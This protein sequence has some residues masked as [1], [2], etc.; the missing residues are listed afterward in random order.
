MI[1][2]YFKIEL[3]DT[4][5]A[6]VSFLPYTLPLGL[7]VV[8][9]N[10]W[11]NYVRQFYLSKVVWTLLEIKLPKE[12]YKSPRAMEVV[13]SSFYQASNPNFYD[14]YW[15]GSVRLWS[16]LELVSI[17]GNV[18][19]FVRINA[20]IKNTVESH[21]Y[22]QFPGI[23][24]HEVED[25]VFNAPYL[26]SSDWDLFGMEYKLNKEDAYPI[27]TYVDYGMEKDPIDELYRIDPM[28]A[29]LEFLGSL[30]PGEQVWVQIL[31]MAAQKR[32]REKGIWFKK[33]DWKDQAK[34]II[35]KIMKRD[36]KKEE[37]KSF[38]S[39]ALSPGERATLEA[40]EKSVSK[41][42]FDCGI[43]T[44]Y[45]AKKEKFDPARA[46]SLGGI[47]RQYNTL[48]LNGFKT[49][50]P[51]RFDWWEDPFDFRITRRKRKIF[52]GY[53]D[54]GY[55]YHPHERTPFVLNT[56][57]LATIFHFP[58]KV[59]EVPTFARI[60]SKKSEPPTNLPI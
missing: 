56:E 50:R 35:D 13:L 44:I 23:E 7:A 5:N 25:Y 52:R 42:G 12:T 46:I 54:R 36:K 33:E 26:S 15:E 34:P 18:Y 41:L 20:K 27:K 11:V 60:E 16:S 47:F 30:G 40:L 4:V 21:I 19:F 32:F 8:F 22:S 43:R 39:L 59:A 17:E 24:I 49:I 31:A 14:K 57:E 53:C 38:G 29:T 10:T 37:D 28:S 55:F 2:D 6:F 9:W 1:L 48:N 45:I 3:I 51:T 58:G